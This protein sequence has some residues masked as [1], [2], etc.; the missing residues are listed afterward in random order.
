MKESMDLI[1]IT[2][3]HETITIVRETR[4]DK[5]ESNNLSSLHL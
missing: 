2:G 5:R 3:N 4:N 1:L